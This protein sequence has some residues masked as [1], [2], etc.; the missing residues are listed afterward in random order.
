MFPGDETAID[1]D[2]LDTWVDAV[3]AAGFDHV[4]FGDHVLGVDPGQMRAGWDDQW[5]G[6]SGGIPAYTYRNVFASRWSSSAT[7]RPAARSSS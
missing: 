4:V 2:G 5:P 6:S 1:T 3:V 7:S